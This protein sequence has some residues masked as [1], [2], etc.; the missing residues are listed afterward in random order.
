L[1]G[2]H[3]ARLAGIVLAAALVLPGCTVVRTPLG[4]GPPFLRVAGVVE[5]SDVAATSPPAW[6]PSARFLA[7]G[8]DDGVWR[9]ALGRPRPRRLASLSSV[10]EVAWSPDGRRL[11][12][13][14]DGGLY[15]VYPDARPAERLSQSAVV[16]FPAWDPRG[17]RLA[18]VASGVDAERLAT[19]DAD[20]GAVRAA[21]LP[22]GVAAQAIG[23]LPD[24]RALLVALAPGG[25]E[26][27][28]LV[29]VE[30]GPRL[31]VGPVARLEVMHDPVVDPFGRWIAYVAAAPGGSGGAQE[32]VV[33]AR[34]DG[35]GRRVLTPP[36]NYT[37][38]SWAPAGTLIAYGT[39]LGPDEVAV[40]I[41]DVATDA[42]LRIADY[43]PEL[44]MYA[45]SIVTRW[46]PD[47][48]RIAFGTDT[49]GGR[50]PV[51]VA[52]VERR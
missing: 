40:E 19:W 27:G 3:R 21:V 26:G 11:A 41:V 28:L 20:R 18:Y 5:V 49:D 31:T 34:P 1:T 32:Q 50:G 44:A 38:V 48:L 15:L 45:R 14:A 7:F 35:S 12:A 46:S 6:D 51:W 17:R 8:T 10:T 30:A 24:G 9:L 13:V 52:T 25:G 29:R 2:L 39:L 22:A 42:R 4:L 47:G 33:V 23:W 16:R 43:H 36:G 37:G